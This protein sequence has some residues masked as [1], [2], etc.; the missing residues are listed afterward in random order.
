MRVVRQDI[1][2]RAVWIVE[3][4]SRQGALTEEAYPRRAKRS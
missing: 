1:A 2:E 3:E 4:A